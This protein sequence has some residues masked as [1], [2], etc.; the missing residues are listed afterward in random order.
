MQEIILFDGFYPFAGYDHLQPGRLLALSRPHGDELAVG[1]DPPRADAFRAE[2]DA[3]G[4]AIV[5]PR[6]ADDAAVGDAGELRQLAL[7]VGSVGAEDGE[8]EGRGG[9]ALRRCG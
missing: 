3:V 6:D 1:V 7:V 2:Q 9:L 5:L 8:E 4:L